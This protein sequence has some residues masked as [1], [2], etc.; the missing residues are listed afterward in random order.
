MGHG[1]A[2]AGDHYRMLVSCRKWRSPVAARL[3]QLVPLD[4]LSLGDAI[5]GKVVERVGL[6]VLVHQAEHAHGLCG[7]AQNPAPRPRG[8]G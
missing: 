3:D 6:A 2:S 7:G 5:T 4:G 1:S 8:G